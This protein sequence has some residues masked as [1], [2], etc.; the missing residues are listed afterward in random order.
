MGYITD[1]A[2]ETSKWRWRLIEID[3]ST[4]MYVTDCDRAIEWNGHTWL[5]H[6]IT[7]SSITNPDTGPTM[8]FTAADADNY[9]FPWLNDTNG[10]EGLVV[11][12]YVA[13]FAIGS[14][15]AAPDDVRQIFTGRISSSTK[16]TSAGKDEVQISCGPPAL[17][18]AVNFPSRTFGSLARVKP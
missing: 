14:A 13:E 11:N 3:F 16:D 4:P 15:S 2:A 9:I 18:S 5:P 6:G 7:V 8:A 12:A 17:T 1:H 10:G